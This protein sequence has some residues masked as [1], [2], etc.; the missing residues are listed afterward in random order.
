MDLK[1]VVSNVNKKAEEASRAFHAGHPDVA[2]NYL[3]EQMLEIGKYFDERTT[4]AGDVTESVTSET[5]SEVP[6]AKPAAVF[7]GPE[8]LAALEPVYGPQ[9]GAKTLGEKRLPQ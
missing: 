3:M 5:A 9:K 8:H 7:G 1:D 4:P 6:E 2:E